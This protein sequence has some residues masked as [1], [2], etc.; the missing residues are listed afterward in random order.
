MEATMTAKVLATAPRVEDLLRRRPGAGLNGE[1][2][3]HAPR[4]GDRT[5]SALAGGS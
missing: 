2:I 1:A 5:L 3:L 4:R